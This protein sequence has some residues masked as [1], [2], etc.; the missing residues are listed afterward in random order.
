MR[1]SDKIFDVSSGMGSSLV[2]SGTFSF[3]QLVYLI[4]L[5]SKRIS[6]RIGI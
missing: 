6:K 4:D 3:C 5:I 2:F 1:S